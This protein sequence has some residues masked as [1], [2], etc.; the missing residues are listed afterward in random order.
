MF[1]LNLST[2]TEELETEIIEYQERTLINT[3]QPLKFEIQRYFPKY[4]E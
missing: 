4:S 3:S 1:E 2:K